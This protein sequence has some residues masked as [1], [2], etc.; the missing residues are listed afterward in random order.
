GT[1]ENNSSPCIAFQGTTAAAI[2]IDEY[3]ADDKR[4]LNAFTEGYQESW[5]HII[6]SCKRVAT[7]KL[8]LSGSWPKFKLFQKHRSLFASARLAFLCTMAS[9]TT[10]A[11]QNYPGKVRRYR[12][13]GIRSVPCLLLL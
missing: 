8:S 6:S 5:N 13:A 1:R 7:R 10:M 2:Q 4:G 12:R 3:S 9:H 11:D